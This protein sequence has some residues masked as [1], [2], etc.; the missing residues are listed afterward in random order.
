[1]TTTF[2]EANVARRGDGKFATQHHNESP[3][4]L[5]VPAR[6]T[7]SEHFEDRHAVQNKRQRL[8]EQLDRINKIQGAHSLRSVAATVLARF[9]GAV[10][11]RVGA[12]EDGRDAYAPVSIAN[13]DGGLLELNTPQSDYSDE[14]MFEEMVQDGPEI[15]ELVGDLD[16]R[17]DSWTEGVGVIHGTGKRQRKS[18]DINLQAAVNAPD[19]LIAEEN[20]PYT[21]SLSEDDQ[22]DLVEAANHGIVAIDDILEDPN[23]FDEHRQFQ[24]ME[25]LKGRVK[26]LLTVKTQ[27]E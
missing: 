12:D 1:M 14:W 25:D 2:D 22:R 9:P 20:T 6:K 15:R 23:S 8:Y 5:E 10:T 21:R 7:V 16:F 18:V 3:V 27:P 4:T 11:L 17:D 26:T 19:P 13:A 24:E